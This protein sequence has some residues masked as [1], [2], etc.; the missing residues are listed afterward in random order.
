[1]EVDLY[2]VA[3]VKQALVIGF[4]I[5]VTND[6]NRVLIQLETLT[7]INRRDNGE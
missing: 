7:E 3:D 4:I 6:K 2:F 1:V 5:R